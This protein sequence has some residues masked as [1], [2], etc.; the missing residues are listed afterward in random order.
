M[1]MQILGDNEYLIFL[2][3]IIFIDNYVIYIIC[4]Y[5][6]I[7]VY[8]QMYMYRHHGFVWEV[9]LFHLAMTVCH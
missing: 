6:C 1:Y 2:R 3:A 7:T 9:M 8:M 4:R 5:T